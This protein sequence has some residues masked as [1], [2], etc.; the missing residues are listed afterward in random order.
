MPDA[1]YATPAWRAL[2][3]EVLRRD[4]YRCAVS[5]CAS[6]ASHCDHIKPRALG[7]A[8]AP[9]NLRSLCPHHHNTRRKGGKR[10][11]AG[12]DAQGWPLPPR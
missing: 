4:G 11:A 2:R 12:T 10:G 3:A 6:R 7:G 8:D 5:G 9:E 1:F